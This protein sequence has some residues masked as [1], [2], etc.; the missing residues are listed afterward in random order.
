MIIPPS[1]EKCPNFKVDELFRWLRFIWKEAWVLA[2]QFSIDEQTTKCQGKCEYKTRCGKF[3]RIG[4]GIQCDCIADDGYTW[5]F[6]FRNEPIEAHLLV[7]GYCPM[8]CRLIHM[9][10]HLRES[11]HRC[12]MDNLF[13]SVKLAQA[14]YSLPN[15]V[16]VHG[17]LRKS[18]RGCPANVVQEDLKTGRA[19]DA[20][21]G[22]VKAAV[23]KGDSRSSNLIVASCYDQKPFYMISHSCESVTWVPI[24][25]KVWSSALKKMV[26]FSFLRWNLSDDYNYEMNDNDVADQLRLVYRI[27]RFQRNVKW[28]WA[29]FLWAYEVSLVNSYVM[30]KRYC[31]LKGVP[32]KWAHHDWNEA[33]G[34]AHVDPDE[35]WPRRKSPPKDRFK[36]ALPKRSTKVDSKALSPSQGRLR[37][38]LTPAVH[39]AVPCAK[40]HTCQLHRWAHKEFNPCE[41]DKNEKPKGS[42][43]QVVRCRECDIHLCIPCFE[44]FHTKQN[45]RPMIPTI[46]RIQS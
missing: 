42:R 17:V 15:P 36:T 19:A 9:F 32:V 30:Y 29:L 25:K 4:D 18:G 23:L 44:I 46:L 8:H 40:H 22:T 11:G 2:E 34:Y 20:A 33:I 38:R 5:D 1:K 43:S 37:D 45:L 14:A 10:M 35:F 28:W 3:K 24:E 6:Y 39:L 7:Q 31:E 27:M 12:K 21:R 41:R 26:D 16:L 13:N